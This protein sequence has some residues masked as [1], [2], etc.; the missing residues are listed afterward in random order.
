MELFLLIVR[1]LAAIAAGGTVGFYW[2]RTFRYGSNLPDL[3]LLVLAAITLMPLAACAIFEA[4]HF[5]LFGTFA[6]TR[7]YVGVLEMPTT[8]WIIAAC[9]YSTVLTGLYTAFILQNIRSGRV[10]C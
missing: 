3:L 7:L 9:V 5:V 4:G 6:L 10:I 8:A 1:F 2:M